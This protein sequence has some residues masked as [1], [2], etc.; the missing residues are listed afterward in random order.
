MYKQIYYKGKE[1]QYIICDD[2][3]IYNTKTHKNLY[4]AKSSGY[5]YVQLTLDGEQRSFSLHRLLAE[6]FIPNPEN[7]EVVHHI[8]GNPLNNSLSN[9]MWVSQKENCLLK[10]N[11]NLRVENTIPTFSQEELDKEIWKPYYNDNF[12]VSNLGRLQNL[13][14]K[15]ITMGS[16]NKNTGYIRWV[17]R[18]D[19][20][21]TEM[22][23]HRA[24]YA[25]FHPDEKIEEIN[26]ID[27]NKANNRLENLENISHSLNV[28]KAYYETKTKKTIFVAVYDKNDTLVHVFPSI[29]E[30]ARA[31]GT[32]NSSVVRNALINGWN[33]KGFKVKQIDKE[34]YLSHV[35]KEQVAL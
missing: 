13:K 7:K 34:F 15:K 29:A 1:T 9:L 21:G 11:T 18:Y 31:L 25:A 16:Q 24:V 12:L 28:S 33:C 19:G 3:V 4:G 22:Q 32:A 5:I 10:Q 35:L 23:A 17:F 14:T 20:K 27:G 30:T 8:D 2:G 26:H 6:Y